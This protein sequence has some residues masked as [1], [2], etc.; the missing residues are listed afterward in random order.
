MLHITASQTIPSLPLYSLFFLQLQEAKCSQAE[1][2]S[3]VAIFKQSIIFRH[4]TDTTLHM[5]NRF[6]KSSSTTLHSEH[7]KYSLGRI[8]HL[9]R[10]LSYVGS[11]LRK[12]L[13]PN[14][15]TLKGV[16]EFQR[17][18]N[19]LFVSAKK[20]IHTSPPLRYSNPI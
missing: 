14:P 7:T 3:D 5:K 12:H 2:L 11:L 1:P 15:L 18:Q 16:E 9:E 13:Q 10:K 20:L 6:F 19:A 17:E 4:T 8:T